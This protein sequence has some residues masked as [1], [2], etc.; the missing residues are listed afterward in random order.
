MIVNKK[1]LNY[2]REGKINFPNEDER[3]LA[4][5]ISYYEQKY[6]IITPVNKQIPRPS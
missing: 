3:F 4:S 6:G 5:E 1:C 2:Y